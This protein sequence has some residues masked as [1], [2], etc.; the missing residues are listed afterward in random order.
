MLHR[1]AHEGLRLRYG[2]KASLHQVQLVEELSIIAEVGYEEYF[3]TVWHML[4]EC[5]ALGIGWI[6]RGSAAD[7]LVCYAL[8]IS[9]VCPIRFELYFKRFLNRDRMALQNFRT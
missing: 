4:Q 9:N 7:S 8:G 3:L 1:L 2:R 6:T 5:A